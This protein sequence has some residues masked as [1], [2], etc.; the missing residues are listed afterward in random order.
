MQRRRGVDWLRAL[1]RCWRRRLGSRMS[2][3]APPLSSAGCRGPADQ[4]DGTQAA[5]RPAAQARHR[6]TMRM[7]VAISRKRSM[8]STFAP[9]GRLRSSCSFCAASC[10]ADL[11]GAAA[12]KCALARSS[13]ASTSL[14]SSISCS[15]SCMGSPL[16]WNRSSEGSEHA[17]W[18]S[19]NTAISGDLTHPS[20]GMYTNL[21]LVILYKSERPAPGWRRRW[22]QKGDT[23]RSG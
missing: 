19:A 23:A 18:V 7:E 14:P 21:K 12:A 8:S 5:A 17:R 10:A 1:G 16:R 9:A 4:A 11:P 3:S 20:A 22:R 2:Q 15:S 13:S 6:R